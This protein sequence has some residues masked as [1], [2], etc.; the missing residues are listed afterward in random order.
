MHTVAAGLLGVVNQ[1]SRGRLSSLGHAEAAVANL[2]AGR[3][4]PLLVPQ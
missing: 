4:H 1:D 3:T 2:P